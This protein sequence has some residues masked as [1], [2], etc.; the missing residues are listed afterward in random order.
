MLTRNRLVAYLCIMLLPFAGCGNQEA[1][2]ST[3]KPQNSAASTDL[4]PAETVEAALDAL[5][6]AD[7]AAFNQ[8]VQH[9]A[10]KDNRHVDNKLFGDTLD[11]EGQEFVE[12]VVEHLAYSIGEESIS[13]DKATVQA[14]ISNSDLSGVMGQL[15]QH[16]M[17]EEYESDDAMLNSLIREAGNGE[18][19]TKQ[20][21]MDL[22][23]VDGMW[24]VILD[25]DSIDAI[26]GGLFSGSFEFD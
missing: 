5:K 25:D 12:A 26:C 14:E 19:I 9:T 4:T 22:V 8:L 23:L 6:Q 2:A 3:S 20:V 1:A 10:G 18:A 7:T 21:V 16:A 24:K 15:I 11:S 13:G 17:G